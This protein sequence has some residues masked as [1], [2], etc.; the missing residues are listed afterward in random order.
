VE[1]GARVQKRA[2]AKNAWFTSLSFA[3]GNTATTDSAPFSHFAGNVPGC[4]FAE[5]LDCVQSV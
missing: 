5:V 3:G 2:D 4:G 1:F